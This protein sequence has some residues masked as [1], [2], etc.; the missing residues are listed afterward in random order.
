M[1]IELYNG[2]CLEVMKKLPDA[3][4]DIGI[5]DLPYGILTNEWDNLINLNEMWVQLKRLRKNKNTPFFFFCNFKFGASIYNSNPEW[6]RYDLVWYKADKNNPLVPFSSNFMHA[7]IRPRSSHELIIVFYEDQPVYNYLK[8]HKITKVMDSHKLESDYCK[9]FNKTHNLY[10]PRLPSDVLFYKK[11]SRKGYH[12][13]TKPTDLIEWILK[14]FSNEGDTCID[15][16]MGSGSTGVAC[17]NL[18]R[19]FIGIELLEKWF[20]Y[21][22]NRLDMNDAVEEEL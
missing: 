2:E 20:S 1:Y 13:S 22:K 3:C 7:R 21:S 14:Y 9:M 6:Y 12:C 8:Y 10:T 17:K 5:F 19:N 18:N 4:I 16:T 15:I 11:N